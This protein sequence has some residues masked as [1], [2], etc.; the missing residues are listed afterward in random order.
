MVSNQKQFETLEA[1]NA[2]KAQ[3]IQIIKKVAAEV[4]SSR[5]LDEILQIMLNTLDEM[6][7]FK[8]SMIL[9]LD[10]SVDTLSVVASH[11]YSGEGIGAKVPVGVGV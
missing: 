2:R 8:H 5:N 3:D 1:E 6:L 11:G 4:N 9:L 10:N 7:A